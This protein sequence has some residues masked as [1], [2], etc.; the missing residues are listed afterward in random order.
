MPKSKNKRKNGKTKKANGAGLLDNQRQGKP[1][2]KHIPTYSTEF[3]DKLKELP[4]L[5]LP[6]QQELKMASLLYG[7][8]T[9]DTIRAAKSALNDLHNGVEELLNTK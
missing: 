2:P 4:S 7:N 3:N 6:T 5:D 8:V 9:A 1:A